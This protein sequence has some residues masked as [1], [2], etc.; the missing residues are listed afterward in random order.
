MEIMHHDLVDLRR[1]LASLKQLT[2]SSSAVIVGER[3]KSTY[4]R[5][6]VLVRQAD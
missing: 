1:E 5:A 2:S 4:E 3:N 6:E